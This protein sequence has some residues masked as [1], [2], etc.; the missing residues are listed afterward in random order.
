MVEKYYKYVIPTYANKSI[1]KSDSL[2]YIVAREQKKI[3]PI[4]V[5]TI[6]TYIEL[7][8]EDLQ[9]K[10]HTDLFW[11]LK[12]KPLKRGFYSEIWKDNPGMKDKRDIVW[13]KFTQNG[14]VGVVA[15]STDINFDDDNTSGRIIDSVGEKWNRDFVIIIPLENMNDKLNRQMV[16]SIIG[17]SLIEK[18]VPILDFYSHNI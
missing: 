13:I 2:R 3:N 10:H 17:N 15:S 8:L 14:Y 1:N 9:I 4:S 5:Y 6:L 18:G 16:E 7:V 11:D 12:R